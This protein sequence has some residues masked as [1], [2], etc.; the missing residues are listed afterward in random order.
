MCK[1]IKRR[2]G[3]EET[4]RTVR[5][6]PRDC[7]SWSPTVRSALPPPDAPRAYK[8]CSHRHFSSLFRSPFLDDTCVVNYASAL[9]L[10]YSPTLARLVFFV[11]S[12]DLALLSLFIFRHIC[13]QRDASETRSRARVRSVISCKI[14]YRRIMNFIVGWK[15]LLK[16]NIFKFCISRPSRSSNEP[17]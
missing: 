12:R 1:N 14:L 2:D 16:M 6:V 8:P 4:V 7:P 11:R 15:T 17:R 5:R 9:S 10:A 13:P 3:R